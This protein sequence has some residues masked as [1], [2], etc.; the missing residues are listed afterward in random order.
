[1]S[2]TLTVDALADAGLLAVAPTNPTDD[3]RKA[4]NDGARAFIRLDF[5]TELSNDERIERAW[6]RHLER[7]ALVAVVPAEREETSETKRIE[8][9]SAI[10]MGDTFEML[11][12]ACYLI[13]KGGRPEIREITSLVLV[14]QAVEFEMSR[15]VAVST[16]DGDKK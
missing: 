12:N 10:N 9:M 3:Y 2:V 8:A 11:R 6:Q 14:A 1:M 13:A 16:K 7:L 5:D 4:F 15:A